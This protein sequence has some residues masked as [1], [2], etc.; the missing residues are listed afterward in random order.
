M[1][2]EKEKS[3]QGYMYNP[4][5][6]GLVQDRKIAKDLYFEYNHTLPSNYEKRTDIM[7]KLLGE[8]KGNF[9]IEQPFYCT[10][11]YNISVGN[12]FFSNIGCTISDGAKVTI[13]DNVFVAPHVSFLTEGHAFLPDLRNDGWEYAYPI[14]VGNN[15]WICANVSILPGVT[16]GD[17]CII[18]A[19][20]VV[21]K[22]IPSGMLAY[23][24]PCRA[25][26]PVTEED[27]NK[28][29]WLEE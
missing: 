22:D 7:K 8:I 25:I 3:L 18:G 1:M 15:V 26:R 2:T 28:F 4:M 24:N 11:G 5:E 23:G 29:K 13:G 19:G 9:L 12:N 27:K 16:I 17:N 10:Y 14:T 20:S 21:T 6:E